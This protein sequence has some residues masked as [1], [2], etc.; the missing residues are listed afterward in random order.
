M[1]QDKFG[2]KSNNDLQLE[3]WSIG[4]HIGMPDVAEALEVRSRETQQPARDHLVALD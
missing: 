3:Y 1:V 4:P 2:A